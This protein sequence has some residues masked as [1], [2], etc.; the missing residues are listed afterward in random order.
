[1]L[2]LLFNERLL[3]ICGLAAEFVVVVDD[4]GVLVEKI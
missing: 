4:E 1:L 2:L 3:G